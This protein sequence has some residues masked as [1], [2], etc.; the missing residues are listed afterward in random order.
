MD[1]RR[2]LGLSEENDIGVSNFCVINAFF[3]AIFWKGCFGKEMR[4]N[5]GSPLDL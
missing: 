4:P 1:S 3:F 5:D 2:A